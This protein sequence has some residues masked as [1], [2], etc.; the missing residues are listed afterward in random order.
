MRMLA[1]LE[2]PAYAALRIVAGM[3]FTC[4]GLQKVFG[5]LTTKA[6]PAIGSQLWIGGVIELVAGA[7]IAIGLGTRIAA[8]LG[9][10]TMAVAYFQFHHKGEFADWKWLPAVNHGELAALYCFVLLFIATRGA[11]RWSFDGRGR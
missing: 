10:G 6:T 5:W 2:D 8:L 7:L 11:G 9:S 3:M 4:H 1:K